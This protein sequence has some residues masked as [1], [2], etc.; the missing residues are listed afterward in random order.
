MVQPT[1]TDLERRRRGLLASVFMVLT[2]FAGL[3]LLFSLVAPGT[4]APLQG[5]PVGARMG[6]FALAV[7][8]MALVWE[9]ERSLAGLNVAMTRQQVMIASFESRLKALE[10]LGAA[11]ERLHL[12]LGIDAALQVVLDAAVEITG[13]RGG[14]VHVLDRDGDLAVDLHYEHAG[15][16]RAAPLEVELEVAGRTFAALEL[17]PPDG[18]FDEVATQA[19]RRFGS[20]AGSA[21]ERA[22]VLDRQR[23]SLT[24]LRA[25]NLARAQFLA[26]ISHE[27]RTPLTSVIG[28]AAT[29]GRHWDRLP[30]TQRREFV[31]S[32]REQGMELGRT[33]DRLLQAARVELEDVVIEPVSHDIRGSITNAMSPFP[34]GERLRVSLPDQMV[35][36]E[37]DP[38]VLDQ[39][40]S[41]LID[42]ALRYTGGRVEVS[43]QASPRN[44]VIAVHDEGAE[45]ES[46][47]LLDLAQS[48][49]QRACS[50]PGFGLRVVRSLVGDH[51]GWFELS[52]DREGT[53]A[54]VTLPRTSN[55]E[56]VVEQDSEREPR[57][58]DR[59]LR[60]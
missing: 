51:G 34:E 54:M 5:L 32:I 10:T 45:K 8:F 57:A 56:N 16:E 9:K 15:A 46:A 36:A 38:L 20:H 18:G 31:T 6:T 7:A 55:L 4:F 33:V 44:V 48:P 12:P 24:Y 39:V 47:P 26:T 17:C 2:G 25:T 30:E 40:L 49:A 29:L 28:Y 37:V 14:R 1:E 60:D 22:G 53:T 21:L 50:G 35:M 23:S 11:S 59:A 13:A 27:L 43:L 58:K 42:N 3:S 52:S 19:L 41:N